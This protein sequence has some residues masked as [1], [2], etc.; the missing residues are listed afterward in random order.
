[1][2]LSLGLLTP[3]LLLQ[4]LVVV[5]VSV[6]G[7]L[8]AI[9]ARAQPQDNYGAD[10]PSA[11]PAQAVFNR[12]PPSP[13]RQWNQPGYPSAPAPQWQWNSPFPPGQPGYPSAPPGDAVYG[14][15]MAGRTMQAARSRHLIPAPVEMMG[16]A[17]EKNKG[18]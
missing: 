17:M 15:K 12:V 9:V 1:M 2:L 11:P 6:A 7:L 16:L 5:G 13:Q 10:S 4:I 14:P 8:A 18:V 3:G